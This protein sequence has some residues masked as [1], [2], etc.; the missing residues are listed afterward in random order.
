MSDPKLSDVLMGR[1][2]LAGPEPDEIYGT[3]DVL[4][5]MEA[6]RVAKERE[7]PEALA[8]LLMTAMGPM[9]AAHKVSGNLPTAISRHLALERKMG[10]TGVTGV[11][12]LSAPFLAP[13]LAATTPLVNRTLQAWHL[14]KVQPGPVAERLMSGSTLGPHVHDTAR[15]LNYLNQTAPKTSTLY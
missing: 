3:P 6:S 8:R 11:N 7:G 10:N 9:A 14:D 12:P 5:M 2:A 13:Y 4:R 15:I 1:N